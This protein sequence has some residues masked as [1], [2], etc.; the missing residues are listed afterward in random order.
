MVTGTV[1][2]IFINYRRKDDPGF[3]IALHMYLKGEF[4]ADHV[5]MDVESGIKPGD[6]FVEVLQAQVARCDIIL[7]IIGPRWSEL[8]LMR[9]A[10]PDDF[11][12]IEIKAALDQRKR[13][14]PVLVGD[15][16]F[17]RDDILP[18]P[19]RPLARKNA[20][21]IRAE[22]FAVDCAGLST[23]LRE[24]MAEAW[25]QTEYA[26]KLAWKI[27]EQEAAAE[28]SHWRGIKNSTDPTVIR[29]HLSNHIAKVPAGTEFEA[30]KKL[31]ELIWAQAQAKGSMDALREFLVEFPNGGYAEAA[32][33][34]LRAQE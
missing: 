16:T 1:G 32:R 27:V 10:D 4:G 3:A 2:N 25:N 18:E 24:A 22:R 9:T 15:A 14:I 30:R 26:R 33:T 29:D 23:V 20:L 5:F 31:E 28:A 6:D 12:V 17:P 8:F 13:V 19:I 7:V 34:K 11:V 21:A